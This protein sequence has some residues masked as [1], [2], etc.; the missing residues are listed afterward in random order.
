MNYT[1]EQLL[2]MFSRLPEP[3]QRMMYDVDVVKKI[4]E[5]GTKHKVSID[6][7]GVLAE[8]IGY[9]MVGASQAKDFPLSLS[10]RLQLPS[11]EAKLLAEEINK[12]IFTPFRQELMKHTNH[13]DHPKT[14]TNGEAL[15][16]GGAPK[17]TAEKVFDD[18]LSK[19]FRLPTPEDIKKATTRPDGTADPYREGLE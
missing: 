14:E 18:R 16:E 4:R 2:E 7:Q 1:K 13:P 17:E 12:D 9:V 6:G 5:I 11:D 3:V 19:L 15:K 8:E 10:Q